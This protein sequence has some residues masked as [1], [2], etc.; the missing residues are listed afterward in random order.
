MAELES[1]KATNEVSVALNGKAPDPNYQVEVIE[2]GK[3][4]KVYKVTI[5]TAEIN[6]KIEA[7]IAE[8]AKTFRLA[9]FSGGRVVP[10]ALVRSRLLPEVMSQQVDKTIQ[11]TLLDILFRKN[12]TIAGKPNVEVKEFDINTSLSFEV[13]FDIMPT[14]PNVAWTNENLGNAIEVFDIEVEQEDIDKAYNELIK[15]VKKFVK[16]DKDHQAQK[17]DAV[18]IDFF[19][20]INGEEFPGNKA[21]AIRIDIGE[22]T[23]IFEDKLINMREGHT[24]AINVKFPD[25]YEHDSE[26]AGKDVVFDIKVLEVLKPEKT[27]SEIEE[28]VLKM[29]NIDTIDKL[30]SLLIN[31]IKAEINTVTRL[32]TKKQLFDALN[33]IYTFEIPEKMIEAEYSQI[34]KGLM[35]KAKKDAENG[36]ELK[37]DEVIQAEARL[38][39]ERRIRSGLLLAKA[40]SENAISVDEAEI[41]KIKEIELSRNT[42]NQQKVK[43]FFANKDNVDRI[44]GLLLEEKVLDSV[45]S[46]IPV[47]KIQVTVKQF[48]NDYLKQIELELNNNI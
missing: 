36:H 12:L 10:I 21:N 5:E 3:F 38:L 20:K 1:F 34:E 33:K 23:F 2:D 26:L 6:N 31:R 32:K 30:H 8:R 4:H 13:K 9:G 19:G 16:A 14:L 25:H 7:E 35:D 42:E 45:L 39:A 22:K 47:K 41:E 24:E 11:N 29:L 46:K 27:N 15:S 17:G 44:R 28:E 18:I 48:Q 37:S 40:A 43:D